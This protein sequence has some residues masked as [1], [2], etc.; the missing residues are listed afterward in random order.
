[1]DAKFWVGFLNIIIIDI[2]LSGDNAVVIGMASRRLRKE[3][4]KKAVLW[5]IVGAVGLR[6]ILT[7]LATWFLLIPYLKAIGGIMLAWIAF[8]LLISDG[9]D[10]S[11]IRAENSLGAAVKTIIVADFVMSLDNVLAVGGAAHGNIILVMFGLGLSIP[12]LMIGSNFIAKLMDQV[13]TLVYIG[14][15]ILAHTAGT[16][17]MSEETI[18][19]FILPSYA[20]LDWAAPLVLVA[21]ILIGGAWWR[22]RMFASYG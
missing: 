5:G 11:A 7:A 8:K 16:M 20:F 12:L 4:R 18:Q 13:P 6:V 21:I 19:Q 15:A 9:E 1:M 22:R 14:A 17:V 10:T 2:V 3:D